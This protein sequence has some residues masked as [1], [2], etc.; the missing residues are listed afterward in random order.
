MQV[1]LLE[2]ASSRADDISRPKLRS[3]DQCTCAWV[4]ADTMAILL[5]QMG[6]Q[7]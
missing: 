7:L 4:H 1:K 3:A 2:K 6:S 5:P